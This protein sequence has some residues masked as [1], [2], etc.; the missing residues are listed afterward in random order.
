MGV[1]SAGLAHELRNPA[2]ALVNAIPTLLEL[3]PPE[4]RKPDT[5]GAVLVEVAL[6]AANQIRERSKNILDYSRAEQVRKYPE[7]LRPMLVRSR[8]LLAT[9]L[10]GRR[11]PGGHPARGIRSRA[12][13][14]SSSRS[15]STSSTTR[16]SPP[17]AAAGSRSRRGAR[18]RSPAV[19]E[20]SAT[21]APGVPASIQDR[22]FDPFFTTKRVGEGTGLGLTIS[23]RIALNHGGDLRVVRRD[24]GTAFRLELPA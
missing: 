2:N 19:I 14:R 15:S 3:L 22:I 9:A 18:V 20:L 6:E 16:R 23:R 12:R 7:L 21:A 10:A 5:A 8:R 11:G 17:A 1:L 24:H 4:Q 13:R